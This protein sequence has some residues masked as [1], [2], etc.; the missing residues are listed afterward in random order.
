MYRKTGVFILILLFSGAICFAQQLSGQVLLPA[1]GE[2][3]AGS[4]SYSQSV[5]ETAVEIISNS[6]FILT[7]GFQQPSMAI[8]PIEHTGIGVD[9]FPNPAIDFVKV[10]L[11]GDDP[12]K[13][14]VEVINI[15]GKISYSVIL[16][17]TTKYYH[18]ETISISGL[19][20]G[21]YFVRVGSYDRVVRRIFKFEKM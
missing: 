1:A 8:Q 6:G 20:R 19:S 11:F 15:T 2:S 17:F 4:I 18:E 5:G 16:D 9:V 10:R 21:F 7:Q 14:M 13:F 3:M 12:R